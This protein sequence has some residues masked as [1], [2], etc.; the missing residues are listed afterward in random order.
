[1]LLVLTRA[2]T[3]IRIFRLIFVRVIFEHQFS[4]QSF[5]CYNFVYFW[6]IQMPQTSLQYPFC[7]AYFRFSSV[8]RNKVV[9]V[10]QTD[11]MYVTLSISRI[12]K[13]YSD[14]R[15]E[16][17]QII[18]YQNSIFVWALLLTYQ[19]VSEQIPVAYWLNHQ[20]PYQ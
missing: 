10:I 19:L 7:C 9:K 5:V 12:L 18:E 16:I 20:K 14:I 3:N 2:Q 1:M 4:D 13:E 15:L 17:Y 8:Q 11:L 6:W